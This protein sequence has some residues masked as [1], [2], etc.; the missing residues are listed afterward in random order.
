M[1]WCFLSMNLPDGSAKSAIADISR[2]LQ[3][4]RK[5]AHVLGMSNPKSINWTLVIPQH[6]ILLLPKND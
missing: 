4:L 2:E 6:Q 1:I 5:T 3:K